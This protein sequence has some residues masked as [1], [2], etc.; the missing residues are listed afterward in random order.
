MCRSN[1]FK[2]WGP[3]AWIVELY[4]VPGHPVLGM[5]VS[6]SCHKEC[7]K[8]NKRYDHATKSMGN[9]LKSS[10]IASEG[11]N[12]K[13]PKN[14]RLLST[15]ACGWNFNTVIGLFPYQMW[16]KAEQTVRYC[17]NM[18]YDHYLKSPYWIA[19]HLEIHLPVRTVIL[20]MPKWCFWIFSTCQ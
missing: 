7:W 9:E 3:Y 20:S 15:E 6:N 5:S 2:V 1:L 19:W 4:F 17:I 13:C 8:R 14:V 18:N 12:G 11:Q 16:Q 10:V